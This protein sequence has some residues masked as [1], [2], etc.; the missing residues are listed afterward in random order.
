MFGD[1]R[2]LENRIDIDSQDGSQ[3]NGITPCEQ[4]KNTDRV[5]ESNAN[6]VLLSPAQMLGNCNSSKHGSLL[7]IFNSSNTASPK[8][9]VARMTRDNIDD[10]P[11]RQDQ[12]SSVSDVSDKERTLIIEQ[13]V[14][15]NQGK[16]LN[17]DA[18][19]ANALRHSEFK[20]VDV[21]EIKKEL[22]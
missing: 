2:L 10:V 20:N 3:V 12:G 18:K 17:N 14:E 16:F 15:G 19:F 9:K 7:D 13:V 5:M 22:W 1:P 8:R 6:S 21:V 4:P 11:A